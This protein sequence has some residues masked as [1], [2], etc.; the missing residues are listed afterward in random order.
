M[1]DNMPKEPLEYGAALSRGSKLLSMMSDKSCTGRAAGATNFTLGDL[2][3]A[4]YNTKGRVGGPLLDSY[5]DFPTSLG[6]NSKLRQR[7]DESED[8]DNV[9][10]IFMHHETKG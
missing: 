1:K 4:A 2:R 7:L 9:E 6:T 3:T 5:N 10:M 8:G